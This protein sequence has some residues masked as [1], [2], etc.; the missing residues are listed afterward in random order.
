MGIESEVQTLIHGIDW[1]ESCAKERSIYLKGLYN[2]EKVVDQLKGHLE[3]SE[4][5]IQSFHRTGAILV[6]F[7][8]YTSVHLITIPVIFPLF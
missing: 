7:H 4:D 6:R 8:H 5:D 3:L 1:T 2:V